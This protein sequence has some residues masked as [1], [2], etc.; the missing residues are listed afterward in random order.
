MTIWQLAIIISLLTVCFIGFIYIVLSLNKLKTSKPTANSN[1]LDLSS[2]E[3]EYVFNV[4]FREELKNRARM[5]FESIIKDN[6]MFLQQDLRLTTADLNEYL[7]TE[8]VKTL[9]EEFSKY[10]ESITDAKQ[11]AI[12]SIEKTSQTIE[13]Q[14]KVLIEELKK[15]VNLEKDRQI[16][17]FNDHLG[18]IVNHY[19]IAAIGNQIDL[20]DQLDYILAEIAHNKEA[21][22][23]DLKNGA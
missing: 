10:Q 4:E 3:V 12:D 20:T 23:E 21:I 16:Q 7:K 14:R 17:Q 2:K 6:A 5:Q 19:V 8:L 11:L 1:I 22:I 13:D 9:K 18:D 15:E